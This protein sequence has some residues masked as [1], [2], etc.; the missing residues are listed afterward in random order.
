MTSAAPLLV[1]QA[2]AEARA[3]LYREGFFADFGEAT[4]PLRAYAVTT[5]VVNQ[6]GAAGVVAIINSAFGVED[7]NDQGND[8]S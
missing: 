8:Q 5:G 2:R 7:Q 3:I 1:F 4:A 6:I